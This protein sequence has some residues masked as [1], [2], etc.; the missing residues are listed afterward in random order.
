MQ[1]DH[2]L[3]RVSETEYGDRYR[4]HCLAM[5]HAFIESA[6]RISDRRHS[7]NTFFLT[8]N[9]ALLGI[10]GYLQ[11]ELVALGGLVLSYTWFRLIKSYRSMNTAKFKVI[12]DME[13]QLPFAPYD[14]EWEKLERGKNP[15]LHTPFSKV[16]TTVPIVFMTLHGVAFAFIAGTLIYR[17][18]TSG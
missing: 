3:L 2:E 10:T 4:D 13:Q 14:A 11:A 1:S 15:K 9:T 17:L 5:Y 6:E 8:V 18:L 12:H 16:E 7:A